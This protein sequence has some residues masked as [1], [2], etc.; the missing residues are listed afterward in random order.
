MEEFLPLDQVSNVKMN[1]PDHRSCRRSFPFLP[2]GRSEK[3]VHVH[4][5]ESHLQ[6]SVHDGPFGARSVA[7]DLDA[8][9]VRIAKVE[10]F[11]HKVICL[12]RISIDMREMG[13]E[14]SEIAARGQQNGKVVQPETAVIRMLARSAH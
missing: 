2:V 5:I 14:S 1:V 12:P 4:R 11:A 10:R 6:L 9:P 3:T 7:I 13:D 8:E